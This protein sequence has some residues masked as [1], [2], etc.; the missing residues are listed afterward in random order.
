[1]L[2]TDPHTMNAPQSQPLRLEPVQSSRQLEDFLR[3]P[4]HLYAHDPLWVPPLLSWQ[5][6]FLDPRRGPFFDIGEAQYFLAYRGSEPVG[7][8]SAHVNRLH[9]RYQDAAD[10]FFG[11]FECQPD[12]EAAAA[13]CQ[14]AGRWLA[15][16]GK[17]R[18]LGPLNFSVY[19]EMGLLVEGFDSMPAIFQTHNPPYY[20]DL[21]TE[22]GFTKVHD[23]Y[24]L[25][26]QRQ[27]VDLPRLKR[28][29]EQVLAGQNLTF[30]TYHPRELDRRAQE[31]FALFNEAWSRNWGHVPL[32]QK[33][34]QTLMQELKPLLRPE[35]VN[36]M[37]DQD[38]LVAFNVAIPDIN[39]FIQ[40]LNGRFGWWQQARLWYEAR[41]RPLRKARGL[42]LGVL[43][44]Y[45]NRRLHHAL[46]CR[47][48]INIVTQTPCQVCDLSLIPE[49]LGPYLKVLA[50]FGARRYKTFRVLGRQID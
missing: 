50:M 19:D 24:A 26:I 16:R 21:L 40:T 42:V 9:D 33:Q 5:R 8:I 3:L 10:G 14:A 25:R 47:T 32:T 22:L 4:W 17:K 38:R 45:Q 36:L 2:S 15:S 12:L 27:D 7:R 13:L 31:V 11:F 20:V 44:P 1:M 35:L 18:L 41:H 37:L 48:T 34:F 39:P 49:T 23:W 46:I 43:Q 30:T 28:H 29:L 6:T